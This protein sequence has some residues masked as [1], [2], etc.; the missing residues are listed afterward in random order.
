[1]A[2]FLKSVIGV[3]LRADA[4]ASAD[5]MAP[6]FLKAT[7]IALR[8]TDGFRSLA[9]QTAMFKA[10]YTAQKTGNGRFGD[11]RWWNGVRYVRTSGAAA[12]VP[13]TS[14]HGK[15]VAVDFASGINT[16]KGAGNA[17]MK[18]HSGPYG[19][20]WPLWAR[21]SPSHEPWHWEYN[22]KNDRHA[23]KSPAPSKGAVN[24]A[25]IA[26]VYPGDKG[27]NAGRLQGLLVGNGY[28]VGKS[29]IDRINGKDSVA[30]LVKFQ[31]AHKLD[32]DGIAGPL[33]WSKLLGV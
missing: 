4:A 32:P 10:R 5:R 7:G 14:N 8:A 22:P 33:S 21:S 16:G 2:T 9:A 28:S 6:A 11:V 25:D 24:V 17:W 30:A 26:R 31:T 1:M 3:P 29:G 23:G 15:G 18:A 12:A 20:T 27:V 13:G 19:W